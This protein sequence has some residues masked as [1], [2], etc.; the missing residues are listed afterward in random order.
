[1]SALADAATDRLTIASAPATGPITFMAWVKLANTANTTNTIMRFDAGG[2]TALINALRSQVPGMYSSSSTTGV[3][4]TSISTGTWVCVACTRDAANAGQ[5]FQGSTPGSLTKTTATVNST[6]TPSSFN[7]FG[8]SSSDATDWFSGSMAYVRLWTA[9]LSDAEIATES[10]TLTSAGTPAARTSG[11]WGSWP[12]AAAALTD[13]SGNGRN[14]T[15]GST[16][17]TADTDPVLSTGASPKNSA[18]F[19]FF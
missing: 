15:A 3:V 9:V 7:L 19:A 8:R 17:L 13:V 4:G 5:L 18:F 1:V 10:Q 12:F 6:G 14:W 2:G 16:A 11:L